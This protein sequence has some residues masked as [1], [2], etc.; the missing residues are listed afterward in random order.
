MGC[1]FQVDEKQVEGFFCNSV[2]NIYYTAD[3]VSQVEEFLTDALYIC[4]VVKVS[5]D[6][7]ICPLFLKLI[8]VIIYLIFF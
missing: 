1:W 4:G 3:C 7:S 8:C 2:V 6:Y 5:E